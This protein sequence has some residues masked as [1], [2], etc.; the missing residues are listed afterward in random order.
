MTDAMSAEFDTVADWTA[1]AAL[2]L[3]PDY[4][5]PAAC[6][7]VGGPAAFAHDRAGVRPLLAEPERGACRSAERLFDL[8]VIRCEATALPFP[9]DSFDV[10]RTEAVEAELERRH[11]GDQAW[12]TSQEQAAT[13][14]R[15]I[16]DG[17]ITPRCLVLR[18]T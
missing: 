8:P 2:A 4:Y 5:V 14:G 17:A 10:A 7:G 15:L 1:D 3:G 9:A 6:R 16:G 18:T 12:R 13:I 11:H